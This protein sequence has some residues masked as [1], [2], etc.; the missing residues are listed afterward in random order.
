MSVE[1]SEDFELQ[2]A[3]AE[4][5][6]RK[7]GPLV[8]SEPPPPQVWVRRVAKPSARRARPSKGLRRHLRRAKALTRAGR[9]GA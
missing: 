3:E 7:H 4:P 6:A 9:S 5:P 1:R 8:E 2:V